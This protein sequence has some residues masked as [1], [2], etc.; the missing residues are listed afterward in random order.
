MSQ[1]LICTCCD[2]EMRPAQT[3]FEYMGHAFSYSIMRCPNCRQVFIPEDLVNGRIS[4][5]ETELEDK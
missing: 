4:E 1:S 5:V 2:V 3:E